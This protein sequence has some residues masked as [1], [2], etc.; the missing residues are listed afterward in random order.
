MAPGSRGHR[1]AGHFYTEAPKK[2]DAAGAT[3]TKSVMADAAGGSD[4]HRPD[5]GGERPG[6]GPC[7]ASPLGHLWRWAH[8]TFAGV[9]T[10][11]GLPARCSPGLRTAWAAWAA[12]FGRAYSSFAGGKVVCDWEAPDVDSVARA[13]A[14]LGFPYDEIVTVEAICENGDA[15]IDTRFV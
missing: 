15:G 12:R 13:Y 6:N 8:G 9:H 10:L 1:A 11:P 4:H 7:L 3:H 2:P 5:R 14:A